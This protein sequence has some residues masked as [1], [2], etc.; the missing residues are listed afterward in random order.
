MSRLLDKR[1]PFAYRLVGE[2]YGR[3]YIYGPYAT[4]SAAKGQRT[5]LL[6]YN[7]FKP[8]ELTIERTPAGDWEQ[9][10]L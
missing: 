7:S 6:N 10:E 5:G 2:K 3:V 9:V 4:K 1:Y 8:S